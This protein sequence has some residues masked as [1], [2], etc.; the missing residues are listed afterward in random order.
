MIYTC[1]AGGFSEGRGVLPSTTCGLLICIYM[2]IA[3]VPLLKIVKHI[4]PDGL[5]WWW[6][7]GARWFLWLHF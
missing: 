6:A 4:S 3:S 7:L 1:K 5:G 2:G